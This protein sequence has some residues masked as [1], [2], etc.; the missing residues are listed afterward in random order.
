MDILKNITC[1]LPKFKIENPKAK[2]QVGK[3]DGVFET[4]YVV[5]VR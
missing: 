2:C 5:E 3:N 1:Y 4:K